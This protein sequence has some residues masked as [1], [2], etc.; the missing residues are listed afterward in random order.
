MSSVDQP[1][2]IPSGATAPAGGSRLGPY[3]LVHVL[4]EGGMGVVHLAVDP[5]GRAVAVKVLRD[6]IAHDADSRARLAREVS[7]LSRVQNPRVAPVLDADTR[8]TRPYVVTR[9]VPGAGLDEVVRECGPFHGAELVRLG[10]GLAEALDAIHA[11]G[12]VHRDLKPGNVLLLDGEPVVIDFGIAHVSDDVRLTSTGLVMGTPG[13]LSPE[14]VAGQQVTTATDWWGWAATMAFAATGRPPFG[15]GPIHVVL[16]RVRDGRADLD[17]LA[18][19]LRGLLARALGPDA[20]RRPSREE[21]LAGLEVAGTQP[22]PVAEPTVPAP[23]RDTAVLPVVPAPAT[24][25]MPPRTG[26]TAGAPARPAPAPAYSTP[27]P[28]RPAPVPTAQPSPV[29]AVSHSP[30][31]PGAPAHPPV[32]LGDPRLGRPPRS[33]ALT[34]LDRKS[35]V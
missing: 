22:V 13:Y 28:V 14:V 30:A 8:G 35:V 24:P 32:Q 25:Q 6:H 19:P 5:R 27:A 11:A 21:L 18:E 3:R 16:D 9:Y 33:L 20:D 17:G 31:R 23:V 2:V 4:G 26:S 15:R 1:A 10:R 34:A 29:G 7:V 12:V